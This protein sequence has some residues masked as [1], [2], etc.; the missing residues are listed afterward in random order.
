MA[1]AH[2]LRVF[3]FSFV[4][5]AADGRGGWWNLIPSEFQILFPLIFFFVQLLVLSVVLYVAGLIVVGGRRARFR[6]AFLISFLGTVLSTVFF[7]FIPYPFIPLILSIFVWLLLIKSL[8][9][10][11]WLG[12][13]AVGLLA[14][15]IFLVVAILLAIIFGIIKEIW[16]LGKLLFPSFV[17]SL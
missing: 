12:A 15:I 6:D 17:F 8:Y 16:E 1:I 3:I 10:T 11:G 4:A 13:I 7:L 9:E 14:M 2:L 5:M